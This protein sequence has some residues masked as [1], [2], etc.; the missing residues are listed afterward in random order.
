[1]RQVEEEERFGSR[2]GGKEIK[3]LWRMERKRMEKK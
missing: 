1:M 3:K 2:K